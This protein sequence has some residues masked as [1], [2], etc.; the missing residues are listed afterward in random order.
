VQAS[1]LERLMLSPEFQPAGIGDGRRPWRHEADRASRLL[2]RQIRRPVGDVERGLEVEMLNRDERDRLIEIEQQ[3]SAA[4][5]EL[6]TLLRSHRRYARHKR[7]RMRVLIALLVLLTVMLL[8]LG[9]P[10]SAMAVGAI[11]VAL[12]RLR[13]FRMIHLD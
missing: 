1:G 2:Q 13:G 11:T 6:A 4:D 10:G 7:I 3:I 8:V 5:P 12:W 9:L